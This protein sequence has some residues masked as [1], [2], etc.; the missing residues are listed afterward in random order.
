ML[1][2]TRQIAF[3]NFQILLFFNMV[4]Y[5]NLKFFL[6]KMFVKIIEIYNYF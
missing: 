6:Y 3:E 4:A 5:E 1:K 2:Y